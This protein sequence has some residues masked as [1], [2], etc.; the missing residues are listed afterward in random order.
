ME[1]AWPVGTAAEVSAGRAPALS[2][3]APPNSLSSS[4]ASSLEEAVLDP[5]FSL[6]PAEGKHTAQY[7]I[8]EVTVE[9]TLA[10]LRQLKV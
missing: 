7:N 2:A 9:L 5:L 1:W 6:P 10:A 4:P 8:Y 3:A